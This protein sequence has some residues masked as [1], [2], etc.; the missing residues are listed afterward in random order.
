MAKN[1]G[2]GRGLD[3][4]LVDNF[5]PG[6]EKE[7]GSKITVSLSEIDTKPDQPR[8]K[9]DAE[10]IAALADSIAANGLL[11][12]ILVR[13]IRDRY[14]II[15]G[16]RRFRASKMAGLTEIPVIITEADDLT[17]AK[18]ALIEN[19]QR[20]DLNPYEEAK[21][22]KVL[23]DEYDLSHEE[24]SVQIGK[25]RSAITNALRLLEL[26]DEAVEMLVDGTL[27]AGHG[28]ALLGLRN[29]TAIV[30]LAERIAAKGMSVRE[31]EEAVKKANKAYKAALKEDNNADKPV[32]VNYIETLEARFTDFTGRKCKITDT[33]NKKTFRVEYRDADD[34]EDIMKK[35]AGAGIFEGY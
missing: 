27:S 24:V 8:K 11:Q 20:E 3:D 18:Y 16:E 5:F 15:A 32:E 6:D 22:Y 14:E 13:K 26:P 33:K 29:K 19:L 35:L 7:S 4:L 31:A 1:K 34:L 17:A 23:I 9:F 21:A 10:S 25:S 30:P 2:L 28:R 12:P